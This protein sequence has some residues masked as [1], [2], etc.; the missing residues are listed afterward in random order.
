MKQKRITIEKELLEYDPDYVALE[1]VKIPGEESLSEDQGTPP[2]PPNI[3][4]Q[5]V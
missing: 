3:T 1:E 4:W 5:L 2:P